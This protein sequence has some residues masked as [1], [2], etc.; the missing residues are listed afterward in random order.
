MYIEKAEDFKIL[1]T[2]QHTVFIGSVELPIRINNNKLIFLKYWIR[3]LVISTQ[4]NA[5]GYDNFIGHTVCGWRTIYRKRQSLQ[6][7]SDGQ[8]AIGEH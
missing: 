6:E 7:M 8:T 2:I 3:T 4:K 1:D 5:I